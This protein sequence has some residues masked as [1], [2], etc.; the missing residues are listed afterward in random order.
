MKFCYSHDR[1]FIIR[2]SQTWSLFFDMPG[3]HANETPK[4]T[5]KNY[6]VFIS[7]ND[8]MNLSEYSDEL[9]FIGINKQ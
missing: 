2:K 6:V 4:N 8:A 1:N 5:D 7:H 3:N 9:F